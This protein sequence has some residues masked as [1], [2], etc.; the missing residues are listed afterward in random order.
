MRPLL[1]LSGAILI[2]AI[3]VAQHMLLEDAAL[4]CK[5]TGLYQSG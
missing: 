3:T 5:S 2:P 1:Q 4:G